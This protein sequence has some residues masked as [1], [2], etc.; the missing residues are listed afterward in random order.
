MT[1]SLTNQ[2]KENILRLCKRILSEQCTIRTVAS[3]LGN[4]TAAFEGV[5]HGRLHYRLLEMDKNSSL[6]TEKGNF[7]AVC[8]ISREGQQDIQWWRENITTAYKSMCPHQR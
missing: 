4:I 8:N 6:K 3:L 1:I 7:E 5:Q 2:K